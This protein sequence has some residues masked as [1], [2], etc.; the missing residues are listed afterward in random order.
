MLKMFFLAFKIA[1]S[2]KMDIDFQI[3][4]FKMTKK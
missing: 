2:S 3:N 1:F 4:L